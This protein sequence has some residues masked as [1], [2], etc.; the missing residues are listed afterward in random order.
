M[1]KVIRQLKQCI[2]PSSITLELSLNNW[3]IFYYCLESKLYPSALINKS[4]KNQLY[5]VLSTSLYNNNKT[6]G[7]EATPMLGQPDRRWDKDSFQP[8]IPDPHGTKTA[9]II[10][11]HTEWYLLIE[12]MDT[13][14]RLAATKES[15]CVS[16]KPGKLATKPKIPV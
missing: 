5:W 13:Y 1:Y 12:F 10:P 11:I 4:S 9:N 16:N 7:S 14:Q 15:S 3:L 8:N 2:H 6:G